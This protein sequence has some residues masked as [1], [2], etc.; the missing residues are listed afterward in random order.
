MQGMMRPSIDPES[1]KATGFYSISGL[2]IQDARG[3]FIGN[4]GIGCDITPIKLT[5]Q[6][7]AESEARFRLI[8]Q[9]LRDIIVLML[10]TGRTIYL[11]PSFN[12]VTG[13]HIETSLREKLKVFFIPTILSGSSWYLR[14]AQPV[15]ARGLRPH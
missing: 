7:I 11:S 9:N 15:M 6:K 3:R 1:G 14:V 5:E 8:A 4:P 13:H 2:P 10:P 12:R